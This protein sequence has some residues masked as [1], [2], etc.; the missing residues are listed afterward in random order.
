MSRR[1]AMLQVDVF[2]ERPLGGN[3]LAVFVDGVGLSDAE[4]Q[5]IAREMN[6]SETTFVLPADVVGADYRV[7]IFT[8]SSELPFAGHP[9]IGTAFALLEARRLAPRGDAFVL[10]QQTLAGVQPIEVCT[11]DGRRTFTMT[12]PTP[13]F[14]PAPALA[15]LASALRVDAKDIDGEPATVVV[16]VGWHIV[17]LRSLDVVRDLAPDMGRLAGIERRTGHAVTVFCRQAEDPDCA[18]RL[19]SFAPGAGIPEDPVCGSGNG[20]VG[21]YL[22]RAAGV[23]QPLEYRA[24]QGVEIGRPGRARVRVEPDGEGWRVQVGGTAVTVVEGV[25]R[26]PN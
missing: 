10:R 6:L 11:R 16:G 25:L 3:P 9:T 26:L 13:R 22:A 23:R 21:A 8:P 4:M 24:E 14:E 12:L 7:R 5:A 18:V 1:F 15:E 20:C 2:T 17:P 19:R